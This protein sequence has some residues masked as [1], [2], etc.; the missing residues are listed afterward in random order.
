MINILVFFLNFIDYQMGPLSL[1]DISL[2]LLIIMAIVH[3]RKLE[4]SKIEIAVFLLMTIPILCSTVLNF[5]KPY[6]NSM[7]F[8]LSLG[9]LT[10]YL[11]GILFVPQFLKLKNIKIYAILEK[12]LLIAVT[13]G[14]LQY[15]I[16]FVFGRD[17]W[18]LYDLG[19]HFFGLETEGTMFNNVGMMRARSFYSEPANFAIHIS[20]I[21]A[22][23]LFNKNYKIA[24]NF[25]IIYVV[26]VL[27]ANSISGYGIMA[28]MYMVY[29]IDFTNRKKIQRMFFGGAF[30]LFAVIC[31]LAQNDYL[32]NRLINLFSLKDHSGVVRTI[33]GFYFL[34]YVPWYGVGIGNH[35]NYYQELA[36]NNTLWFSGSGEFYNNILLAIITMGYVG[37]IVFILYQYVILRHNFKLFIALMITHFGW[38]KLWVSPI[39]IFLM[40]Y[41]IYDSKKV[42]INEKKH[43]KVKKLRLERI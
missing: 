20:L 21:F 15:F 2:L 3:S 29:F 17:S 23:L 1:S 10:V 24:K 42:D 14:L 40:L 36:I 37:M 26:G 31:V 8:I 22:F 41:K 43:F 28:M 32:R 34:E 30:S 9:K 19:G 13:G 11:S 12:Y 16:V 7:D 33:G 38:G 18:P 27:C 6:F 5:Y 39:W 4:I 25:H 35:T